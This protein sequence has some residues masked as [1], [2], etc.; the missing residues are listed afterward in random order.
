MWSECPAGALGRV[1]RGSKWGGPEDTRESH[2]E[3]PGRA[4][5]AQR[6]VTHKGRRRQREWQ[7]GKQAR[8]PS[9]PVCLSACLPRGISPSH[10]TSR[11]VQTAATGRGAQERQTGGGI[12]P[13][14][15]APSLCLSSLLPGGSSPPQA[16]AP[17]RAHAP[18]P[19]TGQ[20][21]REG[22]RFPASYH[23][24]FPPR[25]FIPTRLEIVSRCATLSSSTSTLPHQDVGT[26]PSHPHEYRHEPPRAPA[27]APGP[28]C[29]SRLC[30]AQ[31]PHTLPSRAAVPLLIPAAPSPLPSPQS[32]P[33]PSYQHHA[34]RH[35]SAA[36]R[37]C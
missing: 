1:S 9:L 34:S 26:S 17:R 27:F 4:G 25:R 20:P 37:S 31:K 7:A 28:P 10:F 32:L 35:T 24:P 15:P 18:N 21:R 14:L 16:Q 5:R 23:Q 36:I 11:P 13:Q 12:A 29:H 19:H 22:E 3:V 2:A 8:S 6:Q 33:S 30:T